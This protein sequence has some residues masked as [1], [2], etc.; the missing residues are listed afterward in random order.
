[1]KPTG[2]SLTLVHDAG[3]AKLAPLTVMII[4]DQSTGR[5]VLSEI[6]RGLDNSIEVVTFSEPVEAIEY[7]RKHG[8]HILFTDYNMPKM[9]R[10]EPIPPLPPIF[11]HEHIPPHFHSP[12]TDT[13]LR[14]P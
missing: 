3:E 2:R 10:I 7:A 9:A 4:D 14:Y 6:I 1:M 13:E 8:V 12:L 11:P 5:L